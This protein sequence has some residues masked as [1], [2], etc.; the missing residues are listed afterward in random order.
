MPMEKGT[1]KLV[2]GNLQ[3]YIPRNLE[4]ALVFVWQTEVSQLALV[5][6]L[7]MRSDLEPFLLLIIVIT[8]MIK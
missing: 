7:N 3:K 6:T 4:L 5:V 8:T 1:L 2:K